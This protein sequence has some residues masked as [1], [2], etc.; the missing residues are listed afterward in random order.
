MIAKP[1]TGQPESTPGGAPDDQDWDYGQLRDF[2]TEIAVSAGEIIRQN[3]PAQVSVSATKSSPT[4]PVTEMDRRVED[5]LI[6]RIT[7]QR[8]FDG[9]LGEEGDSKAGTS[10][11]T[12]VIDPIDGT[13]N[14]LYGV[15]SYAVSVA[16]VKGPVNPLEWTVVAGCVHSVVTNRTWA[17]AKGL[18]ATVN[19]EPITHRPAVPLAKSL[20][21][22]G[23]GYAANRRAGQSRVLAQILP[24]IRDIRRLGSAAIDICMQ[25]EGTVDMYYERGL[26]PWDLAAA[27]LIAAEAGS[28]VTGLRGLPASELMTVVGRGPAVLELVTLLE[29]GGADNPNE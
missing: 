9:I 20:V 6:G 23:F 5:Y 12:W 13:V 19:G 27:T 2:A 18:G 25:A 11:L 4:D 15:A 14:Y 16:V 10:G 7:T 1:C 22:T 21:A 28:E 8:P 29:Q 26:Q 17:A 3:R 24:K